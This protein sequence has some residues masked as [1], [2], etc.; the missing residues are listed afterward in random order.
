MRRTIAIAVA[1][2]ALAL[3]GCERG[4]WYAAFECKERDLKNGLCT[5]A[6]FTCTAERQ[7]VFFP[8]GTARC[9]DRSVQ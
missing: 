6:E 3:A 7:L 8:G 9:Y 1:F 5:K 4:G 2:A